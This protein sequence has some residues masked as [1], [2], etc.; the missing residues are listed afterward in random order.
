MSGETLVSGIRFPEGPRWHDGH[1]YFSDFYGH[2]VS[3]T[4]M[5]GNVEEVAALPEQPSGMGWLKDGSHIIVSMLDS[6]LMKVEDGAT[7][8]F[9]EL[10]EF[11]PHSLNDMMVSHSGRIYTTAMPE[12][13]PERLPE[14]DPA[15]LIMV[16]ADG[17]GAQVVA[18]DLNFPNGI[19]ESDDGK[20]LIVAET[21]AS[22]LTAFDVEADGTLSNQRV[23][24]QLAFCPDGIAIDA[25]GCIWA[26][27]CL[28]DAEW[29][30]Q[31]IAEGGEVLE[32]VDSDWGTLAV[33]LGG[34]E[35]RTLFLVESAS[36]EMPAMTEA[37]N[38]RV[39]CVEV[40]V[41]L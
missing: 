24:A 29:G 6:R 37:G 4:D 13:D 11:A 32:R 30:A 2:T 27:A 18:S 34:P 40:E 5:D 10:R 14:T 35:G 16:E 22:R 3:R 12:V 39:R 31:R 7:S 33:A 23:W 41:L 1:L 28:P 17:S 19:V 20:V 25:E 9:A 26:A 38:G 21:F 8:V 36:F 15:N